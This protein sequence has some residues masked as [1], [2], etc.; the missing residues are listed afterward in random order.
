MT[1]V[2][3]TEQEEAK[4]VTYNPSL[5]D[6]SGGSQGWSWQN[7]TQISDQLTA[8]EMMMMLVFDWSLVRVLFLCLVMRRAV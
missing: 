5:F 7:L 2:G 8:D 6:L 3:D 1:E 4:S